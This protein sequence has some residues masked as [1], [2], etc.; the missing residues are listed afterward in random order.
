MLYALAQSAHKCRKMYLPLMDEVVRLGKGNQG[1]VYLLP[2]TWAGNRTVI[3]VGTVS[4][5]EL[6]KQV[7]F[8]PV[9][10]LLYYDMLI[11]NLR[12]PA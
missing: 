8:G 7:G 3:K 1:S 11:Y 6:I 5:C 9:L 10:A 4:C 12:H 2:E